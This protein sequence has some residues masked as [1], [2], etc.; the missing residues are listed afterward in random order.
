MKNSGLNH[1]HNLDL[2]SDSCSGMIEAIAR[3]LEKGLKEAEGNIETGRVENVA[4]ILFDHILH[5]EKLL[6]LVKIT[7]VKLNELIEKTLADNSWYSG[8]PGSYELHLSKYRSWKIGLE[9]F[10]VRKK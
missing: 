8:D 7:I 2:S 6:D 9:Q 1:T 3:I 5:N 4:M 10:L